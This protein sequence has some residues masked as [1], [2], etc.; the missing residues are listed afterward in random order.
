MRPI[1]FGTPQARQG[2]QEKPCQKRITLSSGGRAP[3]LC[4][5]LGSLFEGRA[6]DTVERV[7]PE[8]WKCGSTR[9]KMESPP[10]Q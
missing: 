5:D 3:E 2:P 7:S 4:L 8:E 6:R 9:T 10:S 1:N